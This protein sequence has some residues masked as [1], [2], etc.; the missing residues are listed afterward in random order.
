MCPAK[1]D[2]RRG[3]LTPGRLLVLL[4]AAE[5]F[6]WVSE[7]F[8]WFAFNQHA[9]WTVLIAVGTAGVTMFL[10]VAWFLVSLLFRWR[11]Q[12][13]IRSLLV[14]FVAVAIPCD[15]MAWEMKKARKQR[16]AVNVMPQGQMEGAYYDYQYQWSDHGHH[17]VLVPDD[18]AAPDWLEGLLGHDFF[19]R[20][21][22]VEMY[23]GTPLDEQFQHLEDLPALRVLD[24]R[25]LPVT[26]AGLKHLAGLSELETLVLQCTDVTDSGLEHL[27]G[28]S[29]LKCLCLTGA[30]VTDAGL[31]HLRGLRMLEALDLCDTAVTDAGLEDL[32]ALTG[33]REL[34]LDGTKITDGGLD[35]LK[36]LTHLQ[37]LYVQDTKVTNGGVRNFQKA[38]PKCKVKYGPTIGR[39]SGA[40]GPSGG[41]GE[42]PAKKGAL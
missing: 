33:L 1:A 18:P 31:K 21:V 20:V 3:R 25:N 19:R 27:K 22:V 17:M 35:H 24:I 36:K 6:L 39:A 42:I 28:L 16:E 2:L 11:F 29:Q 15:W 32:D 37:D 23:S 12:Y 10:M 13:S 8:R 26:D 4:V 30:D 5:V 34:Y 7:R 40:A 9:G 14:L 38:L 41:A